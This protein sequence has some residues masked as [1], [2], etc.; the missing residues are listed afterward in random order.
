MLGAQPLQPVC[1]A[2]AGGHHHFLAE[3]LALH[4]VVGDLHAG[5]HAVFQHQIAALHSEEHLHALL[6]QILLDGIV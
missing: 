1:A 3:H 6:G 5:A 4:A 2:A